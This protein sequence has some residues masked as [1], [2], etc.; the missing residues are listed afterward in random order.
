MVPHMLLEEAVNTILG[1]ADSE[2]LA[3]VCS[4]HNKR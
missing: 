2:L 4:T 3:V 1:A